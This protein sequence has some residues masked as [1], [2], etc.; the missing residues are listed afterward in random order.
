MKGLEE[1]PPSGKHYTNRSYSY[2]PNIE[3][4]GEKSLVHLYQFMNLAFQFTSHFI[5]YMKP[6]S[7]IPIYGDLLK[8]TIEFTVY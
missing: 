7:T 4:P 1:Y 6:F 2:P 5:F 8:K 3:I